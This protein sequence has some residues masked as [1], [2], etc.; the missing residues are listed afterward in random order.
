MLKVHNIFILRHYI[1]VSFIYRVSLG[2]GQV[3]FNISIRFIYRRSERYEKKS[4]ISF[5][6]FMS[7]AYSV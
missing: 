2:G 5:N 6:A 1:I 3:K 4:Y 7:V